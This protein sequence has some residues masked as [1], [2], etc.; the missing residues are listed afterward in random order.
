MFKAR[1]FV[2]SE[3]INHNGTLFGG[4][5]LSWVD[6]QAAIAASFLLGNNN[7]VTKIISNI[8]F[9]NSAKLGDMIEI[10][11]HF[12]KVGKTSI[13][14]SARVSRYHNLDASFCD[15]ILTVDNIVFVCVKEGIAIQH[16]MTEDTIHQKIKLANAN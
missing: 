14:L 6:E 16:N 7:T 8:D 2:M 11:I 10:S 1:K 5:V 13:S 9:K 12:K 15:E 3:D 4:K